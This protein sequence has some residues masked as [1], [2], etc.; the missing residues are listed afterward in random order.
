MTSI[1]MALKDDSTLAILSYHLERCGFIVN[2]TSKVEGVIAS[3][4]RID[5]DIIILDKD[6]SGS[7]KIDDICMGIKTTTRTKNIKIILATED[8]QKDNKFI[9]DYIVKPFVPSELIKKIKAFVSKTTTY[10]NNRILSYNG[11]EMSVSS[12]KVTR[13]GKVIHLGPTEFQILQCFLELPEKILSR[14]HIMS[15]AW[16]HNSRVEQRTI[17]VHINR[18]RIA[19]KD[20]DDD[21]SII[22]T[23]RS[24]GYSLNIANSMGAA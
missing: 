14:E 20:N 4:D 6:I 2:S 23:I 17:D 15:H 10:S 11:I 12:F 18:L 16:G 24:A 21:D 3:I 5:P 22:R 19:L 13:L 7:P 8:S 1:L 9:D